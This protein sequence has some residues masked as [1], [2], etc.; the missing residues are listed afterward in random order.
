MTTAT[1]EQTPAETP[2]E[3]MD[4]AAFADSFKHEFQ[5]P[6]ETPAAD[7]PSTPAET[8]AASAPSATPPAVPEP[9][10]PK[11]AQ[12]TEEELAELRKL[13]AKMHKLD[14]GFGTLG[15]VHQ[16][17]KELQAKVSSGAP[18]EATDDDLAELKREFPEFADLLK[19]AINRVETR[20]RGTGGGS[21]V[22]PAQVQSLVSQQVM[23]AEISS[24][25]RDLDYMEIA[26]LGEQETWRTVTG[27]D[28]RDDKGSLPNT[29]WL[30]W[31]NTKPEPYRK[32]V[33]DTWNTH[34]IAQSIEKFKTDTAQKPAAPKSN[35][36]TTRLAAAVTPK[37]VAPSSTPLSDDNGFGSAFQDELKTMGTGR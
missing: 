4:E 27:F 35:D 7:T 31:P 22:D 1:V 11:Y 8:P 30:G 18:L 25:T 24:R 20:R 9:V 37:G 3:P 26:G 21:T 12:I 15:N 19:T 13:Q 34:T 6:T 36:R 16:L 2:S 14:E 28:Q 29:P 32:R 17:V 33:L 5:A 23:A 10:P